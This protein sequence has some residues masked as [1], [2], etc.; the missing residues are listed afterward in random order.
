ML[1][2][3][4]VGKEILIITNTFS[5]DTSGSS[6]FF[7][8]IALKLCNIMQHISIILVNSNGWLHD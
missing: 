6:N 5:G 7:N 8:L 1:N 4:M 2:G 3:D